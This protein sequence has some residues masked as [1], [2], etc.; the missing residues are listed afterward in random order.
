MTFGDE[1]EGVDLQP[2]ERS[3]GG[4][5]HDNERR[6]ISTWRKSLDRPTVGAASR[7]L[8]GRAASDPTLSTLRTALATDLLATYWPLWGEIDPY[9]LA[10]KLL[11]LDGGTARMVYPM[12]RDE[13]LDWYRWSGAVPP[14]GRVRGTPDPGDDVAAIG[15]EA[16]GLMLVPLVAFDAA[17]NRLGHGAGHYDRTLGPIERTSRPLLAGLAY[18]EQELD[19][20]APEDWDVPLDLVLT[21]TRTMFAG[22]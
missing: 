2:S 10:E 6:R 16:V 19:E 20:W 14:K 21:P 1:D 17:G 18:D 9:P 7:Q 11:G 13:R 22:S 8:A 5:P 15:V 3:H 4:R 12:I